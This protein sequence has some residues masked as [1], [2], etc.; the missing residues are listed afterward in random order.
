MLLF[1]LQIY[2]KQIIKG[3][4]PNHVIREVFPTHAP[5]APKHGAWRI[6]P[7]ELGVHV[8]TEL[9][10]IKARPGCS[11]TLHALYMSKIQ[12]IHEK[13]TPMRGRHLPVFFSASSL[14]QPLQAPR[15]P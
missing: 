6:W 14:Q 13:Q 12:I 9:T 4:K 5:D 1:S 3:R 2:H 8:E 15:L 7:T 10:C 11:A